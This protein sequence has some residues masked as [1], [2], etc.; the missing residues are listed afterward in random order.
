MPIARLFNVSA[1][2]P[3]DFRLFYNDPRTRAKYLQWAPFLLTAEDFH[4]G[5][6]RSGRIHCDGLEIEEPDDNN[7]SENDDDDE[8]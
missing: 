2:T 7:E 8:E 3:G 1:Y 5:K 4:A 6:T